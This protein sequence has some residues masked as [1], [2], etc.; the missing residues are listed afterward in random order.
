MT[1]VRVQGDAVVV[2]VVGV[3]VQGVAEQAAVRVVLQVADTFA[4]ACNEADA[5]FPR[6]E[7]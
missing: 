5:V 4:L 6:V 3:V 1:V 2:A 7:V